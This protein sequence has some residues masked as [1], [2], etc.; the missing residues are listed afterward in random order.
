MDAYS[1]KED[2]VLDE[3]Q[4]SRHRRFRRHTIKTLFTLNL[5]L[6]CFA[7]LCMKV[8]DII[9]AYTFS[10]Q[11]HDAITCYRAE[12]LKDRYLSTYSYLDSRANN[13]DLDTLNRSMKASY[14]GDFDYE[15]YSGTFGPYTDEAWSVWSHANVLYYQGLIHGSDNSRQCT[16]FAQMWFYDIY[17]FNSSLDG[18]SGDGAHFAYNVYYANTYLDDEGNICYLFSLDDF[19][20]AMGLISIRSSANP[21]G[22]V[23]CVDEA[24]YFSNTITIS[25]GN[26]TNIG[27]VTIRKEM[28]FDEFYSTYPGYYVYVNPTSELALSITEKRADY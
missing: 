25:D 23:V 8:T 19:P 10:H 3:S 17:G 26:T 20:K 24:D 13:V 7:F 18:P 12:K 4:D 5:F 21:D 2:L 16:F 9:H 6:L 15:E 1:F 11:E 22:H 14:R 27:D 28:S